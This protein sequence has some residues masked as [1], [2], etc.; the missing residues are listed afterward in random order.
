RGGPGGGTA[1]LFS[2][3]PS[4]IECRSLRAAL[5]GRAKPLPAGFAPARTAEDGCRAIGF[6]EQAFQPSGAEELAVDY[7][8]WRPPSTRIVS[9]VMKSLSSSAST[10]FAISISPPQR[11][12]GVACSTVRNSSWLVPVGARIG[13]GAI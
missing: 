13:P 7:F 1:R 4:S 9:P 8:R 5:N 6:E 3:D 12:R 10:A 2:V 11:P